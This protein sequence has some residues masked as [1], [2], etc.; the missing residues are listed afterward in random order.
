MELELIPAETRY[1]TIKMYRNCKLN[2][3]VGNTPPLKGAQVFMKCRSGY[4]VGIFMSDPAHSEYLK[5]E[6]V[7]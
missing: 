1:G 7:H 3:S 4:S 6:I 5:I 2:V